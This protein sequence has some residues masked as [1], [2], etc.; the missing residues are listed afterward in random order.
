MRWFYL[1]SLGLK[2]IAPEK[3]IAGGNWFTDWWISD[4]N[5]FDGEVAGAQSGGNLR[6]D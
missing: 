5:R 2:E 3:E 1:H 4:W 6:L